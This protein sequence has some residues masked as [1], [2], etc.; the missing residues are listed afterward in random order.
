MT[1]KVDLYLNVINLFT[2]VTC[3]VRRER[4]DVAVVDG[5]QPQQPGRGGCSDEP[6]PEAEGGEGLGVLHHREPDGRD[7]DAASHSQR[8]GRDGEAE[9]SIL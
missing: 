4:E 5:R 3:C 8:H 6:C 1:A 2:S 7:E 9:V